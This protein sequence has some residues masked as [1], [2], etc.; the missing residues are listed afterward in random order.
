MIAEETNKRKQTYPA[1]I[2]GGAPS[3]SNQRA[4]LGAVPSHGNPSL[5]QPI[6]KNRPTVLERSLP[7]IFT[8][9]AVFLENQGLFS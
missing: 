4:E 1:K 8:P 2:H 7:I 5:R 3:P 6:S 9:V